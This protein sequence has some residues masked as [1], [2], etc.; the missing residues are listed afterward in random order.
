M[1]HLTPI[2]R[3]SSPVFPLE[4][5]SDVSI[6]A[7]PLKHSTH[8][9]LFI[10]LVEPVIFIQGFESH[11]IGERPPSI[12]RGSLIIRILKPTKLKRIALNF[13]GFS[14]TE[15]PEGIPPKKQEF[16]EIN[17][18][19]NHTWPFYQHKSKFVPLGANSNDYEYLIAGSG[20]SM[21][22]RLPTER[23]ET[24]TS[25]DS[26]AAAAGTAGSRLSDL[27]PITSLSSRSSDISSSDETS[28]NSNK[29]TM[30]HHDSNGNHS[31]KSGLR[32][33][34]PL[35]LFRMGSGHETSNQDTH[36]QQHTQHHHHIQSPFHGSR[37]QVQEQTGGNGLA[38][39]S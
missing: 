18:I 4:R 12:L 10:K 36:A 6:N 16:L 26:P 38:Y 32:S 3:A 14:R 19:V 23:G 22:N 34:S 5:G 28:Q 7:E 2:E 8:I 31:K 29:G 15:W 9:Q 1:H 25:S 17:D 30:L 39:Y 21:Y 37:R 11:H 20:A 13:K 33:L 27:R 35:G 24:N